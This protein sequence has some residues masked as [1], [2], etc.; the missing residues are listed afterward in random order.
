MYVHTCTYVHTY[1]HIY[2]NKD[3]EAVNLRESKRGAWRSQRREVNGRY[4]VTIL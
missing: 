3:K 2:N 1:M 4:D